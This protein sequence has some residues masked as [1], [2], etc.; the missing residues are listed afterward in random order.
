MHIKQRQPI[1]KGLHRKAAEDE[2][3]AEGSEPSFRKVIGIV[4]N[5]W[6]HGRPDAGDDASYQSDANGKRPGMVDVMNKGATD[7]RGRNVAC[8][9]DD[10]TPELAPRKPWPARSY[11]VNVRTHAA[12][13][14]NHL[15]D[16]DENGKG[17]C[18]PKTNVR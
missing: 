12:S 7:K 11:I 17:D 14:S 6:I 2:C 3:D 4:L 16:R 9:A 8:G 15:A 10:R 18:K 1:L 13:V 5:V